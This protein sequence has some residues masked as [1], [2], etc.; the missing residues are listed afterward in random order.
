L[1][2]SKHSKFT[3]NIVFGEVLYLFFKLADDVAEAKK[4]EEKLKNV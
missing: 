3:P 1:L 4:Y 2:S